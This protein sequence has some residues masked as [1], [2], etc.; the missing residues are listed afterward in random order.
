MLGFFFLSG[1]ITGRDA[2]RR[3]DNSLLR[4]DLQTGHLPPED[5]IK[6]MTAPSR[7][8]AAGWQKIDQVGPTR[9][10]S[11]LKPKPAI[12]PR[13]TPII[14]LGNICDPPLGLRV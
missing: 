10:R 4:S 9:R 8:P 7:T 13:K 14:A 1:G 6:P 2:E 3:R 5:T 12:P 11:V